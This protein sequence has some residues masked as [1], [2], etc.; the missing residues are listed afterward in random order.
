VRT[1]KISISIDKNQLRRVRLAA[2]S[3][4]VSVSSFIARGLE[5]HLEDREILEAARKLWKEWGPE[6]VPT[7][8]ERE[9]IIAKVSRPR[10]KRKRRAAA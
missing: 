10:R 8:A 3:D 4:N 7:P 2:R 9:E 6:S 1:T 5:K